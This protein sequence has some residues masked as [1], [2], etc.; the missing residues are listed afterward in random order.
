MSEDKKKIY[1][2]IRNA[3]SPPRGCRGPIAAL[4]SFTGL[5]S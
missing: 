3:L 4:T 1:I 2:Y 5:G